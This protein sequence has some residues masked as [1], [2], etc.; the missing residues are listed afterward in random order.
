MKN[1]KILIYITALLIIIVGS[2]VIYF[3]SDD[4]KLK[5][6]LSVEIN[7]KVNILSF[8]NKPKK[9]KVLTKNKLIDT[10]K[11]GNKKITIEYLNVF[12]QKKQLNFTIKVV[13]TIKPTIDCKDTIFVP[14]NTPRLDIKAK[15]NSKE[16]ISAVIEG[17]YNL[18][19]IGKY[20]VKIVA[21]DS[22]G[23]KVTKNV[24]INV[25]APK[26]SL[27]GY[28]V[29]KEGDAWYS[30]ALRENNYAEYEVN[31]CHGLG[32]G[33]FYMDGKYEIEDDKLIVTLD[34]NT[35]DT[36]EREE[37]EE[38]SIFEMTIQDDKTIKYKDLT[39]TLQEK[40][41]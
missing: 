9:N 23:N 41:W 18:S 12:K 32:C 4:I 38:K 25:E 22:S 3:T 8:I 30:L 16:E 24:T 21:K 35:D 26:I 37:S 2:L 10:S 15:D 31:P 29:S 20:K 19:K 34:H 6:D 39:L 5:E 14:I 36:L 40:Q 27:T 1:K 13:D 17:E 28:Y 7:N 33:L 11:L